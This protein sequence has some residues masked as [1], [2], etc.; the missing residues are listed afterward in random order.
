MN[1]QAR[2]FQ[3]GAYNGSVLRDSLGALVARHGKTAVWLVPMI[4]LGCLAAFVLDL[5]SVNTLAFGVFYTP[6]VAT[7]IFQ[8][9]RRAV[10]VL[11]ALAGTMSITGAFFPHIAHNWVDLVTDRMLS[12]CAIIATALLLARA[13]KIQDRLAEQTRRAEAAEHIKTEVLNNVSQE[14]RAPLY[15]MIGVL[16]LVAAEGR[17]DHKSAL[18]TVRTAGRRLVTTIDNLVDLTQMEG[19]TFPVEPLDLGNL[20][21]RVTDSSRAE[22]RTRQIRLEAEIAEDAETPVSVNSWAL[23]RILENLI[24]DAI[25]Y[26][27]PGGYI[28][29]R[30][31][32]G[33]GQVSVVIEDTSTRPVGT[34]QAANDP[35]IAM[36]LPSAMGLALCQRLARAIGARLEISSPVGTGTIACL[37]LAQTGTTQPA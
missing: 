16:E 36:L 1:S 28:D 12:I 3:P 4:Y 29:V 23:R 19:R 27:A 6:L 9:D 10:W 30:S 37:T 7:S 22:A 13:R 15:S 14:I 35:D 26:T 32:A 17:A 34:I 31:I 8:R 25:I 18:G 33:P 20:L 11:A 5:L 21:R 2:S 24:G